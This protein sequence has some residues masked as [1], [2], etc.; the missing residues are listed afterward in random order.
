MAPRKELLLFFQVFQYL[1]IYNLHLMVMIS[2]F[3]Y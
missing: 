1:T 3:H 2:H